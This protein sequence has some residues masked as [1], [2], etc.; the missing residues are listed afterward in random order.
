M[1]RKSFEAN[2]TVG[3]DKNYSMR[4][5]TPESLVRDLLKL[6]PFEKSD[7]V[8]DAGSGIKKVWFENIPTDNKEE[9]EL[10]EGKDFYLYNQKVDWVV[11]N[12]PF[13]EFIGFIKHS[14]DICKKGF[15]FL[16]NHSRINQLTPKRLQDLADKGFYLSKIHIFGVKKWFG[17]YYFVLFTRNRCEGISWSKINYSDELKMEVGIPPKPKDLGIL[18]NF[19]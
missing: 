9:V 10:D 6:I 1:A 14:A 17:R 16:T 4:E 8:V 18:P 5:Y 11:G 13:P 2:K 15:G 12:P 19:I 3:M 7:L